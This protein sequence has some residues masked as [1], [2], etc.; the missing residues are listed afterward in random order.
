[1]MPPME[2]S[3]SKQISPPT[4]EAAAFAQ[5][6][7]AMRKMIA[8]ALRTAYDAGLANLVLILP[9]PEMER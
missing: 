6:A 7:E 8:D 3:T 9:A 5:G 1:M 4:S 2:R